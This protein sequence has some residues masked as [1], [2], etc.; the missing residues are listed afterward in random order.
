MVF[1][2]GRPTLDELI[3]QLVCLFPCHYEPPLSEHDQQTLTTICKVKEMDP[4]FFLDLQLQN[5]PVWSHMLCLQSL[6]SHAATI[7]LYSSALRKVKL[8]HGD[9]L[10]LP[11]IRTFNRVSL[12]WNL[13]YIQRV[14]GPQQPLLMLSRCIKYLPMD[15]MALNTRWFLTLKSDTS[16]NGNQTEASR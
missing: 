8:K 16:T 6:Q 1:F 9:P 14:I 3:K 13:V 2:D 7:A 10:L 4:K 5:H 12:S 11:K 15:P